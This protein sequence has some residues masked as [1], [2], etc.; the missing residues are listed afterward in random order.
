M[1]EITLNNNNHTAQNVHFANLN[2]NET[3][4]EYKR[5]CAKGDY[6][7]ESVIIKKIV[8]LNSLE[9]EKI[10]N[11]FLDNL[12]LW[13]KIGGSEYTGNERSILESPGQFCEL[14]DDQAQEYRD[15]SKTLTVMVINE[16]TEEMFYVNTEGY[17]YARYVGI[18][19]E[20][21]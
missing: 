1:R 20:A 3:L 7:L 12:A 5:Q 15:N 10:T 4:D 16:K 8:F 9:W 21:S 19:S 18:E 17:S 11:S 2:K 6:R 13:N 14:S